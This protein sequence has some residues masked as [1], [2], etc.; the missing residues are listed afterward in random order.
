VEC[1]GFDVTFTRIAGEK[2][3]HQKVDNAIEN[4]LKDLSQ[5]GPE[6]LSVRKFS[7]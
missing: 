6:L 3:L 2:H 1:E 5:I 4:F 7:L